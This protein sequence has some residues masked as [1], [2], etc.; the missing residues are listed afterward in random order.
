MTRQ[1]NFEDTDMEGTPTDVPPPIPAFSWLGSLSPLLLGPIALLVVIALFA[2]DNVLDQSSLAKAFTHWMQLKLPFINRHA[3]STNYPQA[4]LLA[5]CLTV[6]LIPVLSLVWLVASF[7]NYPKLLARNRVTKQLDVK[8]HL[9][10]IIF[11]IPIFLAAT[12]FMVALPGDPSWAKGFTTHRRGGL[13]FFSAVG[14]YITSAAVGAF[15]VSIRLF[16]D[17]HLRKGSLK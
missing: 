7:V 10:I 12:Y 16:I 2:P 3:D 9:F 5:N 13:A 4:A 15:P 11:G 17:L 8:T 14:L 1:Q 6:A